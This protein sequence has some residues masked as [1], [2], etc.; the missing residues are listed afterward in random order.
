M[1][2]EQE[3]ILSHWSAYI[4]E[5]QENEEHIVEC[6]KKLIGNSPRKILE[7]ACGGGKLCVPL[8]K[9]G[10]RVV[11][12]DIDEDMLY[13]AAQKAETL[14]NLHLLKGDMLTE[15]WGSDFDVVILGSNL[16]LNIITVWDYKQAQKQ[17]I[18]RAALALCAGG[19]LILDFDCPLKL[20]HYVSGEEYV[21]FEGMDDC[22]VHGRYL[23]GPTSA[24]ERSRSV[25]GV[26]RYEITL[27]NGKCF[28]AQTKSVKHFPT[29]EEVC[30]WLRRA[31]FTVES[32]FG[33]HME[34]PFDALH[35][36]AVIKAIKT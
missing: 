22:G 27:Q 11:G 8:A 30:T 2:T 33:G 7:P 29:L 31:G 10:H 18:Q 17:L 34:Q 20:D 12:M 32:L 1:K 36:R 35:R 15:P 28:S 14:Q 16:L 4:Y 26:R 6:I 9:S 21:C 13:Y 25:K 5:Q 24:D 19:I 3:K 23:I